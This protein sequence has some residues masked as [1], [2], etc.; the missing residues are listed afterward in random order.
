M[1]VRGGLT[2]PPILIL[3]TPAGVLAMPT[4]YDEWWDEV[5]RARVATDDLLREWSLIAFKLRAC[6]QPWYRH[7][8]PISKAV[9]IMNRARR[10][11]KRIGMLKEWG[12]RLSVEPERLN[13]YRGLMRRL[14]ELDIALTK[15]I[16]E[17]GALIAQAARNNQ[18]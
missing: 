18:P 4:E 5:H 3:D 15:V 13:H 12:V 10:L 11:L 17:A 2:N 14:E 8:C 9:K 6:T 1:G 7:P 16:N